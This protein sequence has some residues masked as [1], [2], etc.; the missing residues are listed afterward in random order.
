VIIGCT[1]HPISSKLTQVF[2]SSSWPG[3]R[4]VLRILFVVFAGNVPVVAVS[5]EIALVCFVPFDGD[6]LN[7][8]FWLPREAG[9]AP[10]KLHN[11]I[12]IY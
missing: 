2:S 7:C 8:S 9:S 4:P 3:A 10:L 5:E 1:A 12:L 11:Y 6:A